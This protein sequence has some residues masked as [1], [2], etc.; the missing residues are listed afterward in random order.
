[1]SPMVTSTPSRRAGGAGNVIVSR[2]VSRSPIKRRGTV[3]ASGDLPPSAKADLLEQELLS[4]CPQPRVRALA[5]AE[6]VRRLAFRVER[7]DDPG[8]EAEALRQLARQRVRRAW[9]ELDRAAGRPHGTKHLGR[10]RVDRH[11]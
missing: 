3:S 10:L 5:D 1:M 6:R 4:R 8:L 9:S 11:L 2:T 7:R